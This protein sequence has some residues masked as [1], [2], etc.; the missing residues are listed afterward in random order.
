MAKNIESIRCLPHLWS[1][2]I[3]LQ[4]KGIRLCLTATLP[5][6]SLWTESNRYFF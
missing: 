6:M 3:P 2:L 4:H 1:S 5:E